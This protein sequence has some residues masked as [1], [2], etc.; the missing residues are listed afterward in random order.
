MKW[1]CLLHGESLALLGKKRSATL[2]TLIKE[3]AASD[4][5]YGV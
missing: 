3:I 2:L 4:I 1:K 5:D